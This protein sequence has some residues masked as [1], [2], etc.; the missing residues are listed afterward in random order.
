MPS[1]LTTKEAHDS[2]INEKYLHYTQRI[3][4]LI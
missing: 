3:E 4:F 1:F 2:N